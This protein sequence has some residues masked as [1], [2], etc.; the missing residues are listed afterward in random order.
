[1]DALAAGSS[2]RRWKQYRMSNLGPPAEN[3]ET[4]TSA[5]ISKRAAPSLRSDTVVTDLPRR[6]VEKKLKNASISL[7]DSAIM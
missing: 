6:N 7:K 3:D 1:M 4:Y 5:R 2:L